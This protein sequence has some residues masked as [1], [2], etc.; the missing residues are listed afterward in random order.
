[1]AHLHVS[2]VSQL[3]GVK[4]EKVLNVL[5][6]RLDSSDLNFLLHL[7]IIVTFSMDWSIKE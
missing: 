7:M 3:G 4:L 2:D 6:F 1:L 5:E